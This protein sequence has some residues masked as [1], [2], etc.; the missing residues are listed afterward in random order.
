MNKFLRFINF[1][2]LEKH[3][4]IY[5]SLLLNKKQYIKQQEVDTVKISTVQIRFT[6]FPLGVVKSK[7]VLRWNIQDFQKRFFYIW[8]L[9]CLYVHFVQI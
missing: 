9:I 4:Y 3:S 2:V 8:Y 7:C 5:C 1:I 6:L